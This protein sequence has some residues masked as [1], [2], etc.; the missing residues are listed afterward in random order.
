VS[1]IDF[2]EWKR[3][4]GTERRKNGSGEKIQEVH[5]LLRKK[6]KKREVHP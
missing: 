5:P 3:K 4:R 2:G 1:E 6:K